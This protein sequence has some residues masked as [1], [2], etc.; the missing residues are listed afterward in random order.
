MLIVLIEQ[1]ID[2][3]EQ[4]LVEHPP[5]M[6]GCS[7]VCVSA[8]CGEFDG[9]ADEAFG[10][11][12]ISVKV[13]QFTCHSSELLLESFLFGEEQTETEPTAFKL[14]TRAI[15]E[16]TLLFSMQV[17]FVGEQ[18]KK[19]WKVERVGYFSIPDEPNEYNTIDL[20]EQGVARLQ[21]RDVYGGL[22]SGIA[23]SW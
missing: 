4:D 23:W 21:L 18:P 5:N 3:F 12:D 14:G 10:L 11:L 1:H 16:R 6:V 22:F 2:A 8:V 7:P 15:H 13:L 19:I 9:H 17:A 20:D